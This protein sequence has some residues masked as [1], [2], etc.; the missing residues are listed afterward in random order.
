MIS[1]FDKITEVLNGQNIPYMLFGSVAMSLYIM[2]RA[3]RDFDF[4]V[5]LRQQDMM[6]LLKNFKMVFIAIR[7]QYSR[8][9][10]IVV[11]L[12]LLAIPLVLR[13]IL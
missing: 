8:L 3:T 2:P 5:H 9:L 4:I 10:K 13:Q 1:F 12:I 6:H 11:Y 7:R